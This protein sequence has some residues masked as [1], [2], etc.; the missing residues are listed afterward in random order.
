MIGRLNYSVRKRE[1]YNFQVAPTL[2][3]GE[4]IRRRLSNVH[5]VKPAAATPPAFAEIKPSSFISADRPA[6]SIAIGNLAR[7]SAAPRNFL[8]EACQTARLINADT[9]NG[10]AA[11]TS[12]SRENSST[13]ADQYRAPRPPRTCIESRYSADLPLSPGESARATF[14]YFPSGISRVGHCVRINLTA[15]H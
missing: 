13:H 5:G 7:Y 2:K 4:I 10:T 12:R 9:E 1:S 6:G 8:R 15:G 11:A 3:R 14:F